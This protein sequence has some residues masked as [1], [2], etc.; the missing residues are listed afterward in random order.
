[1]VLFPQL[2]VIG[3]T[4]IDI[5]ITPLSKT[6]LPG[7][8]AY[9]AA[10]AASRIIKPVGLVTRI[11]KDYE[12]EFLLSRVIPDGVKIIPEKLTARSTQ[13]YHSEKDLT[14]RDIQLEWGVAP[15]INPQD[16]P[17]EWLEKAEIVHISTMPPAQQTEFIRFLRK[18]APQT[19]I[20]LDTDHFFFE[21]KNLFEQ[22]KENFSKVDI[23]FANRHEYLALKETIDQLPEAIVKFDKDGADYLQHGKKIFHIPTQAV[24]VKDAT[25]AGDMLA[26]TYLALIIKSES[27][28]KAL[29]LAVEVAT[30]SV[31]EVGVKHIFK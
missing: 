20:S 6:V 10:I 23:A 25:G 28:E 16:F 11:G 29:K 18:H 30:E 1:M 21:D 8:G 22:I 4:N 17:R 24:E 31:K 12:A 3:Y 2:V 9:F 14:D 26:G 7:G 15:D 5:N 19:K 13:I 27:K